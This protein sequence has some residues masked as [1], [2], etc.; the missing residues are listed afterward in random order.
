MNVIIRCWRN[1][2]WGSLL[3]I[4]WVQGGRGQGRGCLPESECTLQ[5]ISVICTS[6]IT[7]Q[8]IH[9]LRGWV[10]SHQSRGIAGCSLNPQYT[11]M[12]V[13]RSSWP[14]QVSR[15]VKD[16]LNIEALL[17]TAASSWHIPQEYECKPAVWAAVRFCCRWHQRFAGCSENRLKMAAR[18]Q[19]FLFTHKF[20]EKKQRF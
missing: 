6:Y 17:G 8:I 1:L 5:V 7:M 2:C 10:E 15:S 11:R 9:N 12:K 13:D 4:I 14:H 18:I 16:P 19:S 3:R 20:M